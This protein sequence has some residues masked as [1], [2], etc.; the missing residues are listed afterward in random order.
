MPPRRSSRT[1]ASLYSHTATTPPLITISFSTRQT[2]FATRRANA[3]ACEVFSSPANPHS[4]N[5]PQVNDD[6]SR[7]LDQ[8]DMYVV[9]EEDSSNPNVEDSESESIDEIGEPTVNKT[10]VLEDLH[11]HGPKSP[12]PP[13]VHCAATQDPNA[14]TCGG[15]EAATDHLAEVEAEAKWTLRGRLAVW[16]QEEAVAADREP[17]AVAADREPEV[18][19]ADREPE[20][21]T[22]DR[23]PEAVA[24]DR[25]P[26]AIAAI[27]VH[28]EP[29]TGAPQTAVG[30]VAS[31]RKDLPCRQS[32][33]RRLL[34]LLQFRFQ[35]SRLAE[36]T[37]QRRNMKWKSKLGYVS[38]Q[39]LGCLQT[40]V[41]E[42]EKKAHNCEKLKDLIAK[43]GGVALEAEYEI[44]A[45]LVEILRHHQTL[46]Q[47]LRR[48]LHEAEQLMEMIHLDKDLQTHHQHPEE[49]PSS[50]QHTSTFQNAPH[51]AKD[52]QTHQHLEE[53]SSPAVLLRYLALP[54]NKLL[55]CIPVAKNRNL[56]TLVVCE[57]IKGTE[58][59]PHGIWDL[60][61]LRYLEFHHQ[62]SIYKP[63]VVQVNLQT[64]YWV[65]SI[66]CTEQVFLRIPNVKELGIIARGIGYECCLDNL[67]CLDKL[68]KLK[69]QG[70]YSPIEL[71]PDKAFPQNLKKITFSNT[72]MPWRA[73]NIIGML[74]KLEVLKLKNHGCLG[75]EWEL[76]EKDGFSGLKFLLISE[77][78][79]K[80]WETS[81]DVEK[82]FP[83][84]EG[85]VL[86]NCFEL[87]EM[88]SWIQQYEDQKNR[89]RELEIEED[90][91]NSEAQSVWIGARSLCIAWVENPAYW[92]WITN[93]GHEV[94]KLEAVCWLDIKGT[95]DTKCLHIM[96]IY[97]A[98]LVYKLELWEK[99][100][101]DP[102]FA[103]VRYLKDRKNYHKNQ[104]CQVVLAKSCSSRWRSS[105]FPNC[106]CDGWMEIK[107][108]DFLVSSGNE[109]EV[110][111][112]FWNTENM[113]W[114]CGLI[115]R[116][117]EVRPKMKVG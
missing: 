44:E 59:L 95:L 48:V 15:G 10:N 68:E 46:D 72:L 8:I 74:P 43:I 55:T 3:A 40:L 93:S 9:V 41:D 101:E 71:R 90:E 75:K 99:G 37:G 42:S 51:L 22:V 82:P 116:G 104:R 86:K 5:I 85:L 32:R 13:T 4:S 53:S 47:T 91:M 36:G 38:L 73:M 98:Y 92:T 28:R 27:A 52:L 115:V 96:T 65:H 78:N 67:N 114:K 12:S 23:E 109:G 87:K 57:D 35:C 62:L 2:H 17:E 88:P 76:N 102:A 31:P 64:M 14:K 111:M 105:R 24:A 20:A 69:V 45:A 1:V 79:L 18:V 34:F 50:S 113:G 16:L 89:E 103:S 80:H 21:V 33:F 6:L 54:S 58:E 112:R 97:S 81:D 30:S 108:G 39:G 106:R 19:A 107:L 77:S 60:P 66:Q 100:F 63:E 61:Q 7:L 26:E 29:A 117:I 11:T 84:I 83:V 110:E 94:V 25:E 56:Q 70:A 49:S